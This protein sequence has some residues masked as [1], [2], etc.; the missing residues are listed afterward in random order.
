MLDATGKDQD[1]RHLALPAGGS[2]GAP[3]AVYEQVAYYRAPTATSEEAE[4]V[5]PLSH[6]L[7]ILRRHKWRILAFVIVS[8]AATMIVSARMTP[9]YD[10]TATID[11]DRQMPTGAIG[12]D[13]T[14]RSGYNDSDQ[15]L[16]TQIRLIHSDSVL[17]PVVQKLKIPPSDWEETAGRFAGKVSE[18]RREDAP[19][20]LKRLRVTRPPNTYVLLLTYRS[21]DPEFAADVANAIALSYI[22]NTYT[23][24][25]RASV[26]LSGFMEKQLEELRAKMERSAAALAQFEKDLNV[27]SPEEKTSILS[28]RLLQLNT[29]YTNAQADRVRKEAAFTSASGGSIEALQASAQGEQLRHLADRLDEAREKFALVRAQYGTNHPEYKKAFSQVAELERQVELLKQNISKRVDVEY[30]EALNREAMLQKAVGETKAEFDGVNG[31]SFQY[32]TLK[33]EAETDKG[34]YEELMRKVKE[35]GINASF[36]NSSIRMADPARPPLKP[37]F[38][39]VP[40]N[41]LLAFLASTILGVGAAVLSDMFDHTVRDPDQI[42]HQLSLEVLGSLPV[43]RSWRGRLPGSKVLNGN[44]AGKSTLPTVLGDTSS[45]AHA[46]E[47]AV[48]TLR[49]SILLPGLERTGATMRHLLITS[50]T[51]REGKTTTCAHLAAVHS[52]QKRKTLLI[53]GDLRRPGVY[54]HFGISNDA[55]LSNIVNGE[56]TWRDAIQTSDVFPHL[57]I[58]PAGPA[59]RRAADGLRGTLRTV[60]DEATQDYDL[61]L[62]DAPPLLGFAE[63]LQI[64][65]LVDGV[66]IVTVAGQTNRN[67]V[68]SV[69]TSLRRLKANIVGI[70]LNEVRADMSDR[71]YYYG[72]YGKYYSKYYKPLN[73]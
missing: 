56:M 10:A 4:R 52:Q 50:A 33:Q 16:A 45:A 39:N 36:Q 67:A 38:P 8:V 59:S 35:A 14:M 58:L 62:C 17:R 32:K 12:Q 31:R 18:V 19:I 40:L 41:A 73:N 60:L 34:V 30:E 49:D 26:G 51:P 9:F 25:Y 72:Y 6:Y 37:A 53:D 63:T 47:E 7:W 24:R 46:Y 42:Q 27:I 15:F 21:A 20:A 66:V 54:R 68:N 69:V 22:E 43:V 71:Y 23:I 29:E 70:T 55:G 13:S 64:A 44:G 57:S 2:N 61:I 1:R 28:A 48:R 65:S 5:V 11:I 3:L